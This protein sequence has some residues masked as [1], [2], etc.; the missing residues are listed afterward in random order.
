MEQRSWVSYDLL[1]TLVLISFHITFFFLISLLFF[2]F[3]F[4]TLFTDFYSCFSS[5]CIANVILEATC[6]RV[7]VGD[8]YCDIPLGLYL[9]RG[10]HVAVVGELVYT[11]SFILSNFDTR[12]SE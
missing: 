6:K 1:M 7:I 2:V 10:E 12:F 5:S 4:L 8:L 3:P 9:I 11:L